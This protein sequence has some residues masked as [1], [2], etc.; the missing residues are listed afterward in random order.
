MDDRHFCLHKLIIPGVG[1]SKYRVPNCTIG[2]WIWC[3]ILILKKVQDLGF[4]QTGKNDRKGQSLAAS[5]CAPHHAR[6]SHLGLLLLLLLLLTHTRISVL[7]FASAG[8]GS[9]SS[10]LL[11]L[12]ISFCFFFVRLSIGHLW[13]IWRI[14]LDS[15][16]RSVAFFSW[17]IIISTFHILLLPCCSWAWLIESSSFFAE[18]RWYSLRNLWCFLWTLVFGSCLD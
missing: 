9:S 7:R 17:R 4:G 14:P 6:T 5:R 16:H 11:L 1:F 10:L 2:P 13:E 3:W 8:S 18:A 15:A 12:F